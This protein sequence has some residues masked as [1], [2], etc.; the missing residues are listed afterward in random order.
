MFRPFLA[1]ETV[2]HTGRGLDRTP[3]SQLTKPG[4]SN[5]P[6]PSITTNIVNGG[7]TYGAAADDINTVRSPVGVGDV[8][9]DSHG[10][11]LAVHAERIRGI[12]EI[13]LALPVKTDK[14]ADEVAGN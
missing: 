9:V 3:P 11:A 1:S 10:H 4:R 12:L 2:T 6:Q 7:Y 13:H 8:G 14:D 5:F